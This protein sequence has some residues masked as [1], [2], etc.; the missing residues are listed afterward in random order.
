M[1]NRM[2]QQATTP[3]PQSTTSPTHQ[4]QHH[5]QRNS[6]LSALNKNVTDYFKCPFCVFKNVSRMVIKKHLST[7]FY[8]SQIKRAPVYQCSQCRFRSEWQYA[9]KR[10]II[11]AHMNAATASRFTP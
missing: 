7:H 10:H 2:K 5:H 9:V 8:G 11:T 4:Q 6:Q 3:T 1:L